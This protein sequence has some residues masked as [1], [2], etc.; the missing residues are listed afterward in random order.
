MPKKE[1]SKKEEETIK[2]D[3]VKEIKDKVLSEVNKEIKNSIM[4]NTKKY[5]EDLRVELLEY[6]YREL[7]DHVK[8]E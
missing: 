8:K 7:A 5:K 3:V 6:V 4:E 1:V 2:K